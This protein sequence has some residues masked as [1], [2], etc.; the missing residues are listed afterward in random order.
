[1]SHGKTRRELLRGLT[2]ASLFSGLEGRVS[3]SPRTIKPSDNPPSERPVI[4]V[5]KEAEIMALLGPLGSA[6]PLPGWKLDRVTVGAE[7]IEYAFVSAAAKVR[8]GLVAHCEDPEDA[9]AAFATTASFRVMLDGGAPAE[10]MR[11]L[12]ERVVDEVRVRDRGGMWVKAADAA[13]SDD[14]A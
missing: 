11:A 2:G 12:G 13:R 5:G 4:P 14:D 9:A 6:P 10:V 1:M 8:V 3:P 7:R